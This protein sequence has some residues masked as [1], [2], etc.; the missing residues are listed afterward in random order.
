MKW[1]LC[2]QGQHGKQ[3]RPQSSNLSRGHLLHLD[4]GDLVTTIE[5]SRFLSALSALLR[6]HRHLR[7]LSVRCVSLHCKTPVVPLR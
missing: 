1:C 3:F 5:E 4:F 7:D 2:R 6:P